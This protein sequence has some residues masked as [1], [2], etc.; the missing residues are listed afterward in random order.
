M[1]FLLLQALAVLNK[2]KTLDESY[3]A[4][5]LLIAQVKTNV[6]NIG[7]DVDRYIAT[8]DEAKY[9]TNVK[10]RVQTKHV[11]ELKTLIESKPQEL[12]NL[13]Q[14]FGILYNTALDFTSNAV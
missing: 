6:L 8:H 3:L 11:D 14:S 12:S 7:A 2:Q 4:A 5:N 1:C 9:I 10:N 13:N